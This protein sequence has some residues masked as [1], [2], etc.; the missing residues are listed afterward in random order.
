ML[1]VAFARAPLSVLA[2][3]MVDPIVAI[4]MRLCLPLNN[5]A[6]ANTAD[7]FVRAVDAVSVLLSRLRLE[8]DV[9]HNILMLC[10]NIALPPAA[11]PPV[12][13]LLLSCFTQFQRLASGRSTETSHN[14]APPIGNETMI[15]KN[16]SLIILGRRLI[17][18]VFGTWKPIFEKLPERTRCETSTY[19]VDLCNLVKLVMDLFVASLDT[20]FCS[21]GA[22]LPNEQ[23]E[24]I[25]WCWSTLPLRFVFVCVSKT[26]DSSSM[27]DSIQAYVSALVFPQQ[28]LTLVEIQRM[29]ESEQ[30]F[31][32][33]LSNNTDGF[34]KSPAFAILR[35]GIELKRLDCLCKPD[36]LLE[37][38]TK[39][40][41]T[42]LIN[43]TPESVDHALEVVRAVSLICSLCRLRVPPNCL[44]MKVMEQLI[45]RFDLTFS[46]KD[47]DILLDILPQTHL[48]DLHVRVW[49]IFVSNNIHC[50]SSFREQ[51]ASLW[52]ALETDRVFAESVIHAILNSSN[53]DQLIEFLINLSEEQSNVEILSSLMERVGGVERLVIML[54]DLPNIN[55]TCGN[56]T[57]NESY[58][59]A[60]QKI[61]GLALILSCG[62][63][64]SNSDV[65]WSMTR[66]LCETIVR[67]QVSV[68]MPSMR[69]KLLSVCF[70]YLVWTIQG[71]E[72]RRKIIHVGQCGVVVKVVRII[73]VFCS[74]D[75]GVGLAMVESL[76]SSAVSLV[77]LL[78][79]SKY[80][81]KACVW[82]LLKEIHDDSTIWDS[83]LYF[84]SGGEWTE[85]SYRIA[86]CMCLLELFLIE[87]KLSKGRLTNNSLILIC[88]GTG[89]IEPW[90]RNAAFSLL[91]SIGSVRT[92]RIEPTAGEYTRMMVD[93][94]LVN[95]FCCDGKESLLPAEMRYLIL[96]LSRGVMDKFLGRIEEKGVSATSQTEG[97][98]MDD[99]TASILSVVQGRLG[100]SKGTRRSPSSLTLCQVAGCILEYKLE[101]R[102]YFMV[103]V[104]T[105][106]NTL[107]VHPLKP[108]A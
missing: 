35:K 43:T 42:L 55:N 84:R 95:K 7:H 70:R 75:D 20:V 49:D 63:H 88:M 32:N 96:A 107:Q 27:N 86:N 99:F 16:G 4:A 81:A 85:A 51:R 72:D 28:S 91:T 37:A 97:T 17:S 13:R 73:Q 15:H 9:L 26:L 92:I 39:R 3:H 67:E 106:N 1:A 50:S 14:N 12:L 8:P 18:L 31:I 47:F 5:S 79:N 29:P 78:L 19:T 105:C 21:I 83:L 56:S 69:T 61:S 57:E 62:K 94:V 68:S 40:L 33:E 53:R 71:S 98:V 36:L 104:N 24:M 103:W 38:L 100:L 45:E 30:A 44:S 11:I 58:E 10:E 46:V 22:G 76:V 87:D 64:P 60:C 90:V 6:E 77:V 41:D 80:N 2:E 89:Y 93:D 74:E 102:K 101:F 108:S 82:G 54:T 25:V 23:R 48:R 65:S 59:E 52:N 34:D 66:T